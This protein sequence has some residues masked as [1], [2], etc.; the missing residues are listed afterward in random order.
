MALIKCPECEKEISDTVKTCPHCGYKLRKK[1]KDNIKTSNKIIII[2]LIIIILPIVYLLLI[3]QESRQIALNIIKSGSFECIIQHDLG[4]ATCQHGQICSRCN[5]EMGQ[6]VDHKWAEA[7]CTKK[8]TC[9]I[10]GLT[11]G[12]ALGHTT[13]QGY[14]QNC[15]D[16]ISELQDIYDYL[17][18]CI[19][20]SWDAINQ[21]MDT[22]K[23]TNS[24][25]DTSYVAQ[26]NELDILLQGLLY[27]AADVA[28]QYEEFYDI[29]YELQ[30]A[31]AKLYL[32]DSLTSETGVGSYTYM[33]AM[34]NSLGNCS[35]SLGNAQKLMNEMAE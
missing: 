25:Y 32:F 2:I 9:V 11:Q 6:I 35:I 23:L 12:E 34:I 26:A 13:R 1:A 21:S 17:M 7:T 19:N 31:G 28:Y 4:E 10:C 30:I 3:G 27:E 22:M 14:C 5:S 16:Y 15:K 8:Q 33:T 24:Y 18:T 29:G 20:Y